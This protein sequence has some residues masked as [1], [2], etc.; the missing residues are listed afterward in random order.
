MLAADKVLIV[1]HFHIHVNNEKD[2]L[3]PAFID[4]LNSTGVRQHVSG[5]GMF[6]SVIFPN[7]RPTLFNQLLTVNRQ[8]YFKLELN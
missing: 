2:A 4:I 6:I 3:G 5:L 1:G 8:D 7:R